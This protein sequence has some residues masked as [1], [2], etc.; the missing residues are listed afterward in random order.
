MSFTFFFGSL[1]LKIE[2]KY[3]SVIRKWSPH[4]IKYEGVQIL[5]KL[6]THGLSAMI[7]RLRATALM[8]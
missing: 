5:I 7:V 6:F 3:A 4:C 1:F 2:K 8:T